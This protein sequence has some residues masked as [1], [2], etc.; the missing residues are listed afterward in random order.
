[1]GR[2]TSSRTFKTAILASGQAMSS[3][4]AI[5]TF[6]FLS[7]LLG[8]EDYA[9]YRQTIL[10]FTF[11]APFLALGLPQ[12]LFYFLPGE[13]ER[14]RSIVVEN[15]LL[16]G[17][18]SS[19]FLVLMFAGVNRLVA[20]RFGNPALVRNLLYIAPYPFA[21]L[22]LL[23]LPS[24]LIARNRVR[25]VAVFNVASRVLILIGVV[26][27]CAVVSTAETAVIA[28]VVTSAVLLAP[29]LGMMFA[30]CRGG[31][32]RP[33][34]RGLGEQ[35]R[36]SIPLGAAT[37]VG[38]VILN[39]NKIIVAST[40][41][42]EDFAVYINGAIEIPLVLILPKSI[43]SILL[44]DFV[45]L[46]QQGDSRE[47]VRLWKSAILKCASIMV[48]S[49]IFLQFLAPAVMR[50]L[51]S[52]AYEAAAA[53]FRILALMLLM[54]SMSTDALFVATNNNRFIL[55]RSIVSLILNVV[56]S[57]AL[58][59]WIGYLGA[60]IALVAVAYLWNIP[61]TLVVAARILRVPL[62][63]MYPFRGVAIILFA[64]LLGGLFLTAERFV[65]HLP[66]T[67]VVLGFAIVY[68]PAVLFLIHRFGVTEVS[69]VLRG[70]GEHLRKRR[71][72]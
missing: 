67:V 30:A 66:D 70:F 6:A 54:R 8:K 1:M 69:D 25:Q 58:I 64:S 29:A 34:L 36:F 44:P 27:A 39:L 57:L 47:I 35:F 2:V 56:L 15:L 61:Y 17:L 26:G 32:W 48:P 68:F 55:L 24:C 18:M 28:T 23:S 51:F 14:P 4:V 37:L 41:S 45:R 46:Y 13:K 22:P 7:R 42:T 16:L 10:V 71:G 53:P 19:L 63:A 21:M 12:A 3:A 62:R 43:Q 31:P 60:A 33:S 5:V 49:M 65:R 11:A 50:A 9:T 40:C 72:A 59:R 38:T 52:S 20:W